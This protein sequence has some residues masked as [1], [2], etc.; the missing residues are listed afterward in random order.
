MELRG[1]APDPEAVELELV[2]EPEHVDI[3]RVVPEGVLGL[4]LDVADAPEGEDDDEPDEAR[5]GRIPADWR[6]C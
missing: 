6:R 5:P 3:V 4:D 1:A 2:D